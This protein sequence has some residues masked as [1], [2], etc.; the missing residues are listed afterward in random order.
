MDSRAFEY[1]SEKPR[2]A[3]TTAKMRSAEQ[4]LDNFWDALDQHFKHKTGR[5]LKDL[6]GNRFQPSVGQPSDKGK[7]GKKLDISFA[8]TTLEE[9]TE[10]HNRTI[11]ATNA[12]A[13]GEDPRLFHTNRKSRSNAR[14]HPK[15]PSSPPQ[16]PS[17]EES[18]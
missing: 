3:T 17:Q 15:H 6:E 7:I 13:E 18:L 9:R 8:L 12:K 16:N 1:P 2:T 5:T 11:I 14:N 4:A 10:R